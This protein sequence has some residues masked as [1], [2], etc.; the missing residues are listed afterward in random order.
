MI[1]DSGFTCDLG[2]GNNV[3]ARYPC[4]VRGNGKERKGGECMAVCGVVGTGRCVAQ[5]EAGIE[6]TRGVWR[7]SED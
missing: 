3:F 6:T 2:V 4:K 1:S 5:L 7:G